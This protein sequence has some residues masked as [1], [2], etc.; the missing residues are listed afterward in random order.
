[1]TP[2][3]LAFKAFNSP[4]P[5]PPVDV[6]E[7]IGKTNREAIVALQVKIARCDEDEAFVVLDEVIEDLN[8]VEELRSHGTGV[9]I[10]AQDVDAWNCAF[11][12]QYA[13]WEGTKAEVAGAGTGIV[14]ELPKNVGEATLAQTTAGYEVD[15]AKANLV[16]AR[17][18]LSRYNNLSPESKSRLPR[19]EFVGRQAA[20]D[21]AVL[22][23][24]QAQ[25]KKQLADLTLEVVKKLPERQ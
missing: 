1:V 7:A 14:L 5:V 3:T 19:A 9:A 15:K 12:G 18:S 13:R 21:V 24:Q 23:L 11:V 2:K 8:M 10:S 16:P 6:Q 25:L 17:N 20:Y 4:T 22:V